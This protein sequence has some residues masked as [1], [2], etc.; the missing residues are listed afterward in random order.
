MVTK[1]FHL[2]IRCFLALLWAR[3]ILHISTIRVKSSYPTV[4]CSSYQSYSISEF[5]GHTASGLSPNQA[6]VA[7]HLMYLRYYLKYL[8]ICFVFP[9]LL[10]YFCITNENHNATYVGLRTLPHF[11]CEGYRFHCQQCHWLHWPTLCVT[12]LSCVWESRHSSCEIKKLSYILAL[13]SI[14]HHRYV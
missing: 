12:S 8:H 10:L 1:T 7:L 6:G 13:S 4:L 2:P 11:C 9:C 3:P 5:R 14:H